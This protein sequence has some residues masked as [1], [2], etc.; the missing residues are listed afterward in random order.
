[1]SRLAGKLSHASAYLNK[2]HWQVY[3]SVDKTTLL[4]VILSEYEIAF[5]KTYERFY[6]R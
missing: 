4:S 5:K 3:F 1:M 2:L 6:R